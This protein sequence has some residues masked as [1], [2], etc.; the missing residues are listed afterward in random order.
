MQAIKTML[1][2]HKFFTFSFAVVHLIALF[3]L[4]VYVQLN[5]NLS[6][7]KEISQHTLYKTNAEDQQIWLIKCHVISKVSTFPGQ[8]YF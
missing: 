4:L 7:F 5:K 3:S 8:L 2:N 1:D 6:H